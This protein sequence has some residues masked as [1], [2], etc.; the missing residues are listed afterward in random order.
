M[1][2]NEEDIFDSFT[3]IEKV[4][5]S[6]VVRAVSYL[7]SRDFV[8]SDIK[9]ANVL[10]SNSHCKSYKHQELEKAFSKKPIIYK[11]GESEFYVFTY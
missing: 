8:F 7:H 3:G 9:P 5:A 6:D 11:L 10:V 4:I 1:Y 2:M